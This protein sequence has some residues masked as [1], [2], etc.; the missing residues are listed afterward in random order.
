M[1]QRLSVRRSCINGSAPAG[2][3]LRLREVELVARN[4]KGFTRDEPS[5]TNELK[6]PDWDQPRKLAWPRPQTP[7]G[8]WSCKVWPLPLITRAAIGGGD[9]GLANLLRSLR[10]LKL[11]TISCTTSNKF[12]TLLALLTMRAFTLGL[13]A[14]MPIEQSRLKS[15]KSNHGNSLADPYGDCRKAIYLPS[16]M[17][18][19]SA[20]LKPMPRISRASRWISD[21][22]WM[23]SEP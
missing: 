4:L 19:A 6:L 8:Y 11:F 21:I 22:T 13:G 1:L 10:T 12:A 16:F 2:V 15:R 3:A 7:L 5:I 20:V 14:A 18:I 23:A 17:A 9:E